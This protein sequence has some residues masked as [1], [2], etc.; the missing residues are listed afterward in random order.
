VG[1][2]EIVVNLKNA[3]IEE[4]M[5]Y[6]QSKKVYAFAAGE[7]VQRFCER[8]SKCNFEKSIS[9]FTDNNPDKHGSNCIINGC[10]I[11]IISIS[12]FTSDI[13][14]NDIIL[15]SAYLFIPNIIEQLNKIQALDGI[16]CYVLANLK[17]NGLPIM[18]RLEINLVDECNLKCKGCTH[19]SNL[20]SEKNHYDL[21]KFKSDITTIAANCHV[22][23]LVLLG[24]EPLLNERLSEYLDSTRKIFPYAE[25]SITTNGL[26]ILKQPGKLFDS[27]KT[28]DVSFTITPYKPTTKIV[29]KITEF[30]KAKGLKFIFKSPVFKFEKTLS[31]TFNSN[32]A[33]SM[34]VCI[35]SGCRFLRNGKLYKCPVEG[36]I[37]KFFDTYGIK[38]SF[39]C[40]VDIYSISDWGKV[41]QE[42]TFNPVD[43]CR[44]CTEKKELIDLDGGKPNMEDWIVK[45]DRRIEL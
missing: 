34:A 37:Y 2:D 35:N 16:D 39:D 43:V 7:Y 3:S 1:G 11:P 29:P 15:I 28:N 8:I 6:A 27:M 14:K 45:Y 31:S 24:G 19:F 9:A 44:C 20:F 30:L 18:P 25:I 33:R 12:E 21:D 17:I 22:H 36:M 40:G 26:L 38:N 10:A 32:P 42:L 13:K 41:I 4:F 23:K 5:G